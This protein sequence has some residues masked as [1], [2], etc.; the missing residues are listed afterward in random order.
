VYQSYNGKL[1]FRMDC[2]PVERAG[3]N[4]ALSPDGLQAGRGARDDGAS[5]GHQGN[6]ALTRSAR[7]G[8]KSMRCRR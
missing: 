5:C 1:L 3:Q 4:Y 6:Y 7:P 2:T 8:W